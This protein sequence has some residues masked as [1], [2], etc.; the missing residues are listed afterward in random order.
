M[1]RK[2]G[3]LRR[4]V[5]ATASL[6]LSLSFSLGVCWFERDISPPKAKPPFLFYICNFPSLFF[7]KVIAKTLTAKKNKEKEKERKRK[8]ETTDERHNIE[9][10]RE[11]KGIQEAFNTTERKTMSESFT[12]FHTLQL[13]EVYI[14]TYYIYINTLTN[15][16][17]NKAENDK[18]R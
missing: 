5:I 13:Q 3:M 6:S 1:V 7:Q 18:G 12:S 14:Y 16:G 15:I 2:E 17:M 10:E 8:K 9:R 11:R 4:R